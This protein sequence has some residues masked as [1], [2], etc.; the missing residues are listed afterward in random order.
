MTQCCFTNG[1]GWRL[2]VR[3][4]GVAAIA[5]WSL[6]CYHYM[7]GYVVGAQTALHHGLYIICS[8]PPPTALAGVE[9]PNMTYT[10]VREIF[11]A[12]VANCR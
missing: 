1:S 8:K 10:R 6:A 12:L 3:V 11:E 2:R 5:T 9:F 4:G 7:L